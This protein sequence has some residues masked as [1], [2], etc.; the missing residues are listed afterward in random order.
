MRKLLSASVLAA[1]LA[2]ANG[3]QAGA[4]LFRTTLGPEVPGATGSGSAWVWLDPVANTLRIQAEFSG[5]TGNTTVAHIH[6]C[7]TIPGTGTVGV[8]VTP[9]T[10]TGFPTGVTSG[11]YDRTF[12]TDDTATYTSG[13]LTGAGAGTTDGAEAALIAGMRAGKAYFNI[14]STAFPPGEIR[15]FLAAVPEPAALGLFGLGLAALSALRRRTAA[16]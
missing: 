1:C 12:A 15:G 4:L 6:C 10:L 9:G 16:P 7:T 5:L 13:F 14:H 3:A 2:A 11:S 8:A